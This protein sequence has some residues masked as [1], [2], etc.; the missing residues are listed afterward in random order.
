MMQQDATI[1]TLD[2]ATQT[3]AGKF[4]I[5]PERFTSSTTQGGGG[6][7]K[8]AERTRW[9]VERW[10]DCQTIYLSICLSICLSIYLSICPS[11]C[12]SICLSIYLSICLSV[13]LSVYLSCLCL[14]ICL[15]VYL[16]VYLYICRIGNE[17][18]L[19]DSFEIW[20]LEAEKRGFSA[21]LPSISQVAAATATSETQQ[22]CE[23]SSENR[24]GQYQ[25]R[26]NFAG[27]RSKMESWV[28]NWQSRTNA[29]Y[30]FSVP[31]LERFK[32]TAPATKKCG[33][34]IGCH[35]KCRTGNAKS[36]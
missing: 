28:L 18:T 11:L 25:K 8:M 14:S 13:C 7:F 20:Q 16:S 29:F 27:L 2:C 9:W 36:S 4:S 34:V 12:L 19:R 5:M 24:T 15:S 1:Q 6:N 10:V 32:S 23:T 35:R 31:S 26:N 3:A 22:F 30:D 33:Q 17:A 21:R